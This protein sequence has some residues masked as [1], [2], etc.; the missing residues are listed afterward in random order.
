[1]KITSPDTIKMNAKEFI[2]S[3]NA[4]L[5]WEA[6]EELVLEKYRFHMQD[7]VDYKKGDIIVHDNQVAYQLDF[8]IKVALSII[9]DRDGECITIET[10]GEQADQ[11]VSSEEDEKPSFVDRTGIASELAEMIWDINKDGGS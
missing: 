11:H 10:S 1:M 2:D 8:D 7:E 3:I 4:E 5:D 6:I 9:L